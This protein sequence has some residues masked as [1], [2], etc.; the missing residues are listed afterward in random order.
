MSAQNVITTPPLEPTAANPGLPAAQAVRPR[1]AA[2]GRPRPA[3][4]HSAWATS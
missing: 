1:P 2:K 3:K 4:T